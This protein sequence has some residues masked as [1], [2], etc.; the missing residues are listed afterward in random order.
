MSRGA[1]SARAAGKVSTAIF[2]SRVLGLVRDQ[3]FAKLF[4]AGIYNDAWL[5]A[6]R[7]PNLLRDLFA[8]GAL[9]AA[10]VPT[11]TDFLKKEG[12]SDAWYLANLVMS[13]LLVILGGLTLVLIFFSDIF[14]HL[15][16]A[17]FSEVPGKVEITSTLIKILSPFLMLIAMASVAMGILNTL[18][19]YF[20]PAL[21]PALFNV[22]LITTAV[23]LVPLFEDKGILPIYAMGIGALIGGALQYAIQIPLMR[24]EGY[25]FRLRFDFN[26]PGI[27]KIGRLIGP[28]IVGVSAV[29]VNVLINTQLA[30]FLQENGPVSWLSYAFRIMYLPI[31]LFGVAVGVVNLKEVSSFAASQKF[32]ELKETVANSLRLVAFLAIPS[33]VGLFVLSG[34]IVD[35]LFERGD[36]TAED[37]IFTSYALMAYALGLFAYSCNKVFVPTFYALNDTR[38]PVRI[39]VLAV[40]VNAVVNVSL[41]LTLPTTYRYVGLAVGTSLSVTIASSLLAFNFWKR[42]GSLRGLGVLGTLIKTTIS[43]IMMGFVVQVARSRLEIEWGDMEL[44]REIATLAVCVALGGLVFFCCSWILRVRELGYLFSLLRR[45]KR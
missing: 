20:L 31:G 41:I 30:S 19:H 22:S 4:G 42:L 18:N 25:R 32:A 28:A 43:A 10:F 11:F 9:S 37:T 3:F 36:F 15:L 33:T 6:L 5:V 14:V 39:T 45:E 13:G 8:E 27:R 35:V 24:R 26:H 2:I 44:L 1:R 40:I 34:L 17:G 12:R 21:A 7:I 38:T 16:A 23:F 29:Q